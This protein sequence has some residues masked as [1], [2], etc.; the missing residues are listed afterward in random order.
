MA[1]ASFSVFGYHCNE[2]LEHVG[3]STKSTE[4]LKTWKADV[5]DHWLSK[6][7]KNDL[8][9][10]PVTII[11]KVLSIVRGSPVLQ[12]VIALVEERLYT[13]ASNGML[14]L[15]ASLPLH[16]LATEKVLQAFPIPTGARYG[17]MNP[18]A[19]HELLRS[20]RSDD[21]ATVHVLIQPYQC[22]NEGVNLNGPCRLVAILEPAPS[23]A[24]EDQT[25][26]R[27]HRVSPEP[28][29]IALKTNRCNQASTTGS[30]TLRRLV[31]KNTFDECVIT[32]QY[33]KRLEDLEA[34]FNPEEADI[35]VHTWKF[36]QPEIDLDAS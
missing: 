26:A 16:C 15:C 24:V 25:V 7:A 31:T 6:L 5:D 27:V 34:R 36:L 20:F 4:C 30:I 28:R 18:N 12:E 8:G 17:H 3:F 14:M 10:K 33:L 1:L 35:L 29:D 9:G 19:S 32:R 22:G 13:S 2:M 21:E 23:L 11:Q